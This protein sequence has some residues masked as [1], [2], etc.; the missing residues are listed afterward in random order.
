MTGRVKGKTAVVTS[1]GQGI[2][3][4]VALELA[5]E[6]AKVFATDINELAL[7]SL[8][9]E[10]VAISGF[11]LD[12]L[13]PRDIEAAAAHTG[14]PDIL[15]NCSGWVH[16]GTILDCD[17]EAWDRSFDL[18]VKAHY[19]TIRAYLPGMVRSGGASII[20]VASVASTIKGVPN[21]FVYGATKGAVIALTKQIAADFVAK[22]IR[23]N[24][25][26]P[27]TVDTPSLH[28]RMRAQGNYEK[29]RA[30][31]IA[32]QPIGRL[33]TADE[34]AHLA[35]YLASDESTFVTGQIHIIDGGWSL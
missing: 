26:C 6:G 14:T 8:A 15:V 28:E 22:R 29:A 31:F 16:H 11:K 10:H 35:L 1:A 2:G 13:E 9:K 20:N 5:R 30:A 3:R 27:G 24:A 33:C 23:C 17:E 21:R 4:A 32:R 18:N 25:V 34:I 19:R 7:M 12:V